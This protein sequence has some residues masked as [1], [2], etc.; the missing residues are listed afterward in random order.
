MKTYFIT[1]VSSE[2][3]EDGWYIKAT[4]KAKALDEAIR[5]NRIIH[6]EWLII[7]VII[8]E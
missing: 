2:G 4:T 6:S 3:E 8:K 1:F 5:C 7:D